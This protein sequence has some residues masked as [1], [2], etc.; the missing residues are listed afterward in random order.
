MEIAATW[1]ASIKN[2]ASVIYVR[3]NQFIQL[4]TKLLFYQPT[5]LTDTSNSFQPEKDKIQLKWPKRF[6]L[7]IGAYENGCKLESAVAM[8]VAT[9]G[10]KPFSDKQVNL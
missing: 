10:F 8:A 7:K 1:V 5:D 9:M 4:L 2:V 3:C 6:S